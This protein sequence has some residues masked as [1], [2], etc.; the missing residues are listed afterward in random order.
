MGCHRNRVLAH[1]AKGFHPCGIP[2]PRIPPCALLKVWVND[3]SANLRLARQRRSRGS[4]LATGA[5]LWL[6][7]GR[8][9]LSRNAAT[10]RENDPLT[11]RSNTTVRPLN[12]KHASNPARRLSSAAFP[13]LGVLL[14]AM[15]GLLIPI[16]F[17]SQMTYAIG[18]LA[19]APFFG[20]VFLIIHALVDRYRPIPAGLLP[21]RAMRTLQV[22]I[23]LLIFGTLMEWLQTSMGRQAAVHDAIA[24]GLGILAAACWYWAMK[25][26]RYQPS[27]RWTSRGLLLAAGFL[28]AIAWWRPVML[29][30]EVANTSFHSRWMT[31]CTTVAADSSTAD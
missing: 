17:S 7:C 15:F 9:I 29:L 16:P 5:S 24:N 21:Q 2:I 23:G 22:A 12:T 31:S 20:L 25:I 10:E 27:A 3:K 1:P 26:K 19:H 4:A 30:R 8:S 13:I 18:D 14:V 11:K 28:L 6:T